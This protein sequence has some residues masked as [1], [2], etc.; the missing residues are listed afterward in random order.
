MRRHDN[1][2]KL[3]FDTFTADNPDTV[4]H[5]FKGLEGLV[6][7]LEV[8][9][10]GETNA[11]HHA[12][13]V[14]AEGDARFQGRGNNTIFQISQTIEGIYQFAEATLIQTDCHRIDG[15]VTAV[16]VIFQRA[17]LN[18]GFSRIVTIA[19]AAGTD[20]LHF[21]II[22]LHLRRTKI[23][24]HGEMR[25][26]PQHTFQFLSHTDATSHHNDIDII[27]WTLKKNIAHI[28]AYDIAFQ[29]K[30]VC[31]LA[32]LVEYILVENFGQFFVRI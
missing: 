11:T 16:L 2:I 21:G 12:Q 1:L 7:N 30:S 6:F 9:L 8:Q 22:K 19:L 3:H 5:A 26:A 13:R 10:G 27:G 25:L 14:I 31:S 17:I 29:P 4:G 28:A 15:K 32:D 18:N 20:E 23:F 24:E